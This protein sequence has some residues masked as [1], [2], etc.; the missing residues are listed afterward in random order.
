[1][2]RLHHPLFLI[3]LCGLLGYAVEQAMKPPHPLPEWIGDDVFAAGRAELIL[4]ETS[5]PSA[6]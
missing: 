4:T 5:I 2:R 6:P 3:L 1:M